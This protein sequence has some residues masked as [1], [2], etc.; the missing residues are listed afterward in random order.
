VRRPRLPPKPL[1]P[2]IE[3]HFIG[4]KRESHEALELGVFGLIRNTHATAAKF[5]DDAV[6]GN[7]V[8]SITM[9][10]RIESRDA[11][12]CVTT[13]YLG[14]Y[15]YLNMLSRFMLSGWPLFG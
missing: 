1:R 12:E 13:P 10:Q 15:R 14:R 7:G 2:W 3:R 11:R 8:W 9:A 4:K 5:F 6:T